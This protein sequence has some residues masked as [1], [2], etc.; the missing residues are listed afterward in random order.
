MD[1]GTELSCLPDVFNLPFEPWSNFVT[2]KTRC[3]SRFSGNERYAANF[4]VFR[5]AFFAE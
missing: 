5:P 2:M 1:S 3:R 4:T